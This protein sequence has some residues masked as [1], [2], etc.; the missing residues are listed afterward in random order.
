MWADDV[1]CSSLGLNNFKHY[2]NWI[3][4]SGGILQRFF[5][6]STKGSQVFSETISADDM[7]W[8]HDHIHGHMIIFM[9]TWSYSWISFG[10]NH[11]NVRRHAT[12]SILTPGYITKQELKTAV[13]A[14]QALCS[15]WA[16]ATLNSKDIPVGF[17]EKNSENASPKMVDLKK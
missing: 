12:F 3:C 11:L 2:T 17:F 14:P 16:K 7:T 5:F 13:Q 4:L 9:V 1:V 10:A 15:K 8:S 6:L